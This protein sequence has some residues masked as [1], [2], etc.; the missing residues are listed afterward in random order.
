MPY[1]DSTDSRIHYT[2]DGEGPVHVVFLHGFLG[3]LQIWDRY[4]ED[5][6]NDY[7]LIRVDL[8]GHGESDCLDEIHSMELMAEQVQLVMDQA[9][10]NS[11]HFVG[12]S[13][14]GYVSMALASIY[15]GSVD[16][17]TLFNSTALDDNEQKKKDRI[18]TIRVFELSPELFV[19]EAI[20]NLFAAPS[21]VKYPDEV[22]QLKQIALKTGLAGAAPSLRGMAQRKDMRDLL[23][24]SG[25][26]VLFLS[27]RYDNVIPIDLSVTQAKEVN[28]QMAVLE[29]SGHMGFM[30]EY[31]LTLKALKDFWTTI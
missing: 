19:N 16:S 7:T 25:K 29:N 5:L 10:V 12:H 14:G 8:P 27:G 1:I 23:K 20:N 22:E 4:I 11:A 24:N 31:E 3:S 26:P 17:I 28:A 2:I 18:R 30:E 15:S 21:L 9:N 13:M 6:G